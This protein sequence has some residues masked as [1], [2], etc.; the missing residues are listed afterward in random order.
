VSATPLVPDLDLVRRAHWIVG[1]YAGARAQIIADRPGNPLGAEVLR[2]GTAM[3]RR[4]PPFGEHMFNRSYGF[5]D[6][7]LAEAAMVADW[8]AEKA[9]RGAFE[10]PPG[11]ETA[12]LMALL[13]AR[14]YRQSGFHTTFAGP[15]ELPNE[16][17]PGVEVRPVNNDE[18]LAA[19]SDV[20]HLGWANTGPRVPMKPWLAAPGWRLFL[21]RCDGQ[22]AGAAILYLAGGDA[23][24]ADGAVDPAW[25]G[26]GVHRALLDRRCEV[27]AE[28]G[29]KAVFSGAAFLST[30]HRNMVR[31]G[32][33]VLFTQA[34]WT[35]PAPGLAPRVDR[36]D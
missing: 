12:E 32:L 13:A 33:A 22:P 6:R 1:D 21:G 18:D 20:Y 17:S 7:R 29:A 2:F 35:A 26:R 31:K 36:P 8:Y 5:D 23:Y 30:S 11:P 4:I 15:V 16:G 24:L 27:A 25:R 14:G 10:I 3:A 28:A 9:V 34:I 19:F